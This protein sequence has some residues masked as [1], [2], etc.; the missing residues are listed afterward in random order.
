LENAGLIYRCFNIQTPIYPLKTQQKINQFKIYLF[1]V[2]ILRYL[3]NIS[4]SKI[5]NGEEMD[6]IGY[7]SENFI[8]TQLKDTVLKYSLYYCLPQI[9]EIDFITQINDNIIPIEVKSGK[10]KKKKSLTAFNNKYKPKYSIVFS[11]KDYIKNGLVI[12]IPL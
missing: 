8:L 5:I 7:I 6:Y 1:D 10:S 9:M 12:N 4:Y 3:A 2:G 11:T